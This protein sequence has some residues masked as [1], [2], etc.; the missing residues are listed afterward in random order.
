[1][2]RLAIPA[3]DSCDVRTGAAMRIQI[4]NLDARLQPH[5][6][7]S[8]YAISDTVFYKPVSDRERNSLGVA[9]M[10]AYEHF[11]FGVG[12]GSLRRG[13]GGPASS[14]SGTPNK[15]GVTTVYVRRMRDGGLDCLLK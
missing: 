4:L 8:T 14:C 2:G 12:G 6:A 7:S 5:M 13:V 1:M 3:A 10:V 15:S 9:L 11:T